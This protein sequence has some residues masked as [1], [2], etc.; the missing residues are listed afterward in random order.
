MVYWLGLFFA[1]VCVC[2]SEKKRK[3]E[4]VPIYIWN[5]NK[6]SSV[7]WS[8]YICGGGRV[9]GIEVGLGEEH[10]QK[11]KERG[12]CD[13]LSKLP[14]SPLSASLHFNASPFPK[15]PL[16][17]GRSAERRQLLFIP[18]TSP[19][20][21]G[22]RLSIDLSFPLKRR[23]R[24]KERERGKRRTEKCSLLHLLF[25]PWSMACILCHLSTTNKLRQRG[26]ERKRR[27]KRKHWWEKTSFS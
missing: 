6:R 14:L 22:C 10:R 21:L 1:H 15:H 18:V 2:V 9:L 23:A 19:P 17:I 12:G 27:R 26:R 20:E 8:R 3:R 5:T 4:S 13:V 11:Q 25:M 16:F 24:E 7:V